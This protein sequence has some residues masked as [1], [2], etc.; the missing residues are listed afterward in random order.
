MP[1]SLVTPST[2]EAICSPNSSRTSSSEALV[3]STVS[4]SSAAH[5][6]A[7][8]SRMPAQ[9]F[10]TPTGC[11]MKSSP[12]A[13]R[14]SA[15]RSQEN[16]KARSTGSRSTRS[17]ASSEY[18][19]MTAKRSP[20]SVRSSSVSAVS[21]PAGA[22]VAASSTFSRSKSFSASALVAL[23]RGGLRAV[24]FLAGAFALVAA[25]APL[26]PFCFLARLGRRFGLAASALVVVEA[27]VFV[28]VFGFARLPLPPV[29]G[30]F[31][32]K[33]SLD[34]YRTGPCDERAGQDARQRAHDE[35]VE[36]LAGL[37]EQLLDRLLGATR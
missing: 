11:T 20:S 35:R 22:W 31:G 34:L 6:V 10:A 3:S 7:V 33:P 23:A 30:S 15:W 27:R 28:A 14:W 8:S 9:I 24:A 19:S 21:G 4:C 18:S 1:V 5:S 32:M 2:S 13:R 12:L 25:L 36:L 29:L 17:A 37:R 16:T 26:L